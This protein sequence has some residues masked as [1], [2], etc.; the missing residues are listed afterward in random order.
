MAEKCCHTYTI[1]SRNRMLMVAVKVRISRLRSGSSAFTMRLLSICLAK[2]TSGVGPRRARCCSSNNSRLRW[3]RACDALFLLP[4]AVPIPIPKIDP[5]PA[6]GNVAIA[7]PSARSLFLVL[8]RRSLAPGRWSQLL[9]CSQLR[10]SR[11]RVPHLFLLFSD[12]R[13]LR[14][15]L[16]NAIA[17][18][19]AERILHQPVLQRVEADQH[20]PSSRLQQRWR[21][22]EQRP[23]LFQ[24]VIHSNSKCLKGSCC[25]MNLVAFH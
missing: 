15:N 8:A 17:S 11:S 23:D 13:L 19:L 12:H 21:A 9:R 1:T 18:G 7:P 25:G 3:A 10:A 6:I 5:C 4:V 2:K 24:L 20:Q 22:F 14:Q 16:I